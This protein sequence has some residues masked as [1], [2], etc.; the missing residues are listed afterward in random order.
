MSYSTSRSYLLAWLTFLA[1][2]ALSMTLDDWSWFARSGAA[3]VAIGIVLTS[4]Q[5]FEHHNKLEQHR[6]A[7]RDEK[8]KSDRGTKYVSQQHQ[9]W[10]N[11]NSIRQLIRSRSHEE[12]VWRS[13]FS[14]FYMLVTGTLV[15]GF[16]DL[17]GL[18]F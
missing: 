13:E 18:L 9:D 3:V 14:G 7:R 6:R 15:W 5:I 11:K 17:L 10:A 16:G 12:E 4:N 1:G 8:G 2:I